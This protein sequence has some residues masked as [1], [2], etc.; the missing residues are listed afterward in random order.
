MQDENNSGGI[1]RLT[2]LLQCADAAEAASVRAHLPEHVRLT[3]VEPGCLSFQINPTPDPLIWRVDEAF[4]FISSVGEIMVSRASH[5]V[6]GRPITT[7]CAFMNAMPS[8][9]TFV[10]WA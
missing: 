2:G 3:R 1:V 5:F 6:Q 7:F 4:A 10:S 9:A 8:F